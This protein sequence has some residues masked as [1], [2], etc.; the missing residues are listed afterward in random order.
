MRKSVILCLLTTAISAQA[1]EDAAVPHKSQKD[2]GLHLD[3]LD[4]SVA[5]QQNFNQFANG[6]WKETNPI[7]AEYSSWGSFSVLQQK[8]LQDIH[9][10]LQ[11][12]SDKEQLKP[13]SIEQKI[14]DF[15]FSGM[16]V[17][18]IDK[19]G[20]AP[21]QEEFDRVQAIHSVA[22][23]QAEIEH[24]HHYGIDAVFA[25][26]SMQDFKDSSKMIGALGQAG[27]SL[28]D[29]DYYLKSEEKFQKIRKAF[30]RHMR[31]VFQM[32]GDSPTEAAQEAET[33]LR[34]ETQ[35]AKGS[36]SQIAQRD[37]LAVYHM[38][39][40]Q[41]LGQISPHFDW[42]QYLR[43]MGQE[44][45]TSLN[46]GMPEFIRT[47]DQMLTTTSLA[48]WKVYLRWHW[49]DEVA[50]YLSQPFVEEDFKMTK[51]ISGAQ[52]LPPRWKQVVGTESSVLG[53]AVGEAYVKQHFSASD[54]QQVI[55]MIAHI[56]K[57]LRGDLAHLQ[58]MTEKTRQAAIKKL[59]RIEE[60]VGYPDKWWDYSSLSIDRSSYVWNVLRASEFLVQRDLNKIGKPIDRTEWAMTPQTVNAYYDASMNTINLP[61]GILQAPYFDANAP[62][63]V[64]YG[65]IGVVIGH[66]I[67]HGFDDQGSQ[68]DGDGNLNNWWTP[69]DLEKFKVATQCIIDQYSQY[70]ING[71]VAVQGPLVV[72]EATADL[73]GLI[74]AYRAFHA[75][76]AYHHQPTIQGF[77]PD[78]QFFL[79]F[80]H[81]WTNNIRPEYAHNLILI[82]PHPPAMYRVNG[83]LANSAD[84]K[85]VFSIPDNSPMVN[86]TPCMIW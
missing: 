54:R 51:T 43:F 70:K 13:G 49:I 34:M 37:P 79:S 32:L 59:D 69:T 14:A 15:Y 17:E 81:I 9:A 21:L 82:D 75:A 18:T 20:V 36:L 31:T 40:P 68:F 66:E 47:F 25:Y 50:G 8:N 2:H 65:A 41:E 35:L 85:R 11:E 57:V 5:P 19:Q 23:L 46:V 22:S 86:M 83:T 33:V 67:T 1:A 55:D 64:N 77:T 74:L 28:P 60:R 84:F 78:Q 76:E 61:S 53:F 45:Q 73:G 38:M 10:M 7:P 29:R 48:D 52:S 63:A 39:T 42:V 80:A 62:L 24:M 26:G 16:N 3:W 44:K 4:R 12:L 72:G 58:W 71:E 6:R 56:R 27:L 30:V